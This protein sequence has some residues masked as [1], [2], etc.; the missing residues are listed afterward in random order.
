VFGAVP[1]LGKEGNK[2]IRCNEWWR[3][4]MPFFVTIEI[5]AGSVDELQIEL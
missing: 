4:I 5:E 2:F 1:K 3:G